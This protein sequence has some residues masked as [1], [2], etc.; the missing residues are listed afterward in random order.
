MLAALNILNSV[1]FVCASTKKD[2]AKIQSILAWAREGYCKV[3]C[4]SPFIP[5]IGRAYK[6]GRSGRRANRRTALLLTS[7]KYTIHRES[8]LPASET[9]AELAAFDEVDTDPQSIGGCFFLKPRDVCI[10]MCMSRVSATWPA[11]RAKTPGNRRLVVFTPRRAHQRPPA[12]LIHM[13]DFVPLRASVAPALPLS[14]YNAENIIV[15]DL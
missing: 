3:P 7:S 1:C 14:S 8:D 12:K 15:G 2:R 4:V 11:V 6:A 9:V 10:Y 13:K 5:S